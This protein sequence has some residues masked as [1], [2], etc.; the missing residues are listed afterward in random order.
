MAMQMPSGKYPRTRVVGDTFP[1]L[2]RKWD[3]SQMGRP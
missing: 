1:I 2:E 3:S